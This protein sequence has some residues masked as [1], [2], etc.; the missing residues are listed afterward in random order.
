MFNKEGAPLRSVSES[1]SIVGREPAAIAPISDDVRIVLLRHGRPRFD[2]R[3]WIVSRDMAAWIERYDQAG[4]ADEATPDALA[5]AAGA[6]CIVAST[7][8]RSEQ[9]AHLLARGRDVLREPVFCE[10]GLPYAEWRLPRLPY[11]VWLTAYRISWLLGFKA[12]AESLS[13]AKVRAQEAAARLVALGRQ[14]GSVLLVGH[15]VM[16]RLIAQA[17]LS[18]GAVGARRSRGR[19]WDF[20]V[21][22]VR[23]VGG[24]RRTTR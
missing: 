15:G 2:H 12:R 17:L 23:P 6:G 3:G 11:R 19:Y 24:C 4:V 10:A 5:V 7:L 1:R 20:D 9:S 13:E 16:N 8:A 18:G 21:Y 14:H 22:Q